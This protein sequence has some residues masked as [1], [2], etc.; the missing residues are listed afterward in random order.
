MP[1]NRAQAAYKHRHSDGTP[2]I[3]VQREFERLYK[4]T[5]ELHETIQSVAATPAPE[6]QSMEQETT[7]EPV[8]KSLSYEF[9]EHS[10]Y[11][12]NSTVETPPTI[13]ELSNRQ[14]QYNDWNSYPRTNNG[15]GWIPFRADSKLFENIEGVKILPGIPYEHPASGGQARNQFIFRPTETGIYRINAI[16]FMRG[17]G[18]HPIAMPMPK[19]Y[20]SID[21]GMLILEKDDYDN[22]VAGYQNPLLRD[23]GGVLTPVDRIYTILDEK[24]RIGDIDSSRNLAQYNSDTN[25]GSIIAYDYMAPSVAYGAQL[26]TSGVGSIGAVLGSVY[27]REIELRGSTFV[28]LEYGEA[29]RVWYKIYSRRLRSDAGGNY[30]YDVYAGRSGTNSTSYPADSVFLVEDRYEQ[31]DICRVESSE[32]LSSFAKSSLLNIVSKF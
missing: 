21:R 31:I 24:S 4:Q 30:Y 28:Y 22:M 25:S 19:S 29:I 20:D 5:Q 10:D 13:L 17:I 14:P 3:E 23:V 1:S 15:D 18:G 2:N 7:A 12:V 6:A 26:Y 8:E 27:E 9:M 11:L 32:I 16:M